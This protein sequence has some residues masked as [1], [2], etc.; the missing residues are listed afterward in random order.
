MRGS[1]GAPR[2]P[3]GAAEGNSSRSRTIKLEA[4]TKAETAQS[5]NCPDRRGDCQTGCCPARLSFLPPGCLDCV[6]VHP[7]PGLPCVRQEVCMCPEDADH[8]PGDGVAYDFKTCPGLRLQEGGDATTWP[9]PVS[10]GTKDAR[11][12]GVNQLLGVAAKAPA[13]DSR[14]RSWQGA[15]ESHDRAGN[16]IENKIYLDVSPRDFCRQRL[17]RLGGTDN[18][19]TRRK[20]M[21]TSPFSMVHRDSSMPLVGTSP[22]TAPTVR[23]ADERLGG[24]ASTGGGGASEG[25]S[26]RSWRSKMKA[27]RDTVPPGFRFF[28]PVVSIASGFIQFRGCLVLTRE[29][30]CALSASIISPA[31]ASS[32]TTSRRVADCVSRKAVTQRRDRL[33]FQSERKMPADPAPINWA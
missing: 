16:P 22:F 2:L 1:V 28:C 25:N 18:R 12:S 11:R 5:R 21:D 27:G 19:P 29:F 33:L 14:L 4:G 10:V 32:P 30:V 9:P 26:N 24:G 7:V 13:K 8:L 31:T 20:V 15:E 17:A 3:A 23:V 6:R